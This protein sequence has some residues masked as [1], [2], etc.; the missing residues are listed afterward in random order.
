[1]IG[2]NRI[3][4]LIEHKDKLYDKSLAFAKFESPDYI[5]MKEAMLGF[6]KII[7]H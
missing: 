7:K 4:I 3:E 5:I 2:T 1:M 6:N